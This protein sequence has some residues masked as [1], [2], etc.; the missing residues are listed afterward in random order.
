MISLA[1]LD[2]TYA[3]NQLLFALLQTIVI[4]STSA[5]VSVKQN[6]WKPMILAVL[7]TPFVTGRVQLPT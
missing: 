5:I 4:W 7:I 6:T 3:M 1:E 2:A